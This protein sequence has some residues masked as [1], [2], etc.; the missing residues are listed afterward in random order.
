MLA[1]VRSGQDFSEVQASLRDLGR[2]PQH[3][4]IKQQDAQINLDLGHQVEGEPMHEGGF[5]V[6]MQ[7]AHDLCLRAYACLP[8]SSLQDMDTHP[9]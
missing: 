8:K 5:R 6:G 2:Q 9:V 1:I 3:V 4:P 7:L